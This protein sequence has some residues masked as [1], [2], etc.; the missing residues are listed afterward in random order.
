MPDDRPQLPGST[1]RPLSSARPAG[2]LDPAATAEVTVVLRRRTPLPPA[3][4]LAAP[5]GR[6]EF[7]ATYG[8]DP[9]D[10]AAVRETL[11]AEGL[12]VTG[13]DAASRRVQVRGDVATLRR[14]FAAELEEVESPDPV[15]GRQVTHRQRTGPLAVPTP[16]TEIV[17]AVLGLDDRPQARALFRPA[18][19]VD[20]TF[21]PLE[22]GRVYRFPAGT[23]GSGQT[24]AILEL[25][26]GYTDDD[27]AA[28]WSSVGLADPPRVT[29]VG[30]DGAAN[31]PEGDP[32]GADGEV[33]LD[34]E[35]AG[36][37]APGADLVVYFAPNTDRGF[38]D[39]LTTAVHA[40]PTPT[41]VSISW[42][43]NE[44]EWTAQ[45]RTAMDDAMADAAAL[46]VTVCAAAGDDGSTD[47]A[48]DGQAHVDFPASSPHALACGGTTL[49]AD[50]GTGAVHSET[51][52]FH[53]AGRG[54]TGG[55]VSAV[56]PV[57]AWQAAVGVPGDADTGRPGRGVPDV[58][59]DAD[60]ATGYQVRV[61]GRDT[62]IGG[63][64]AVS[65]LWSAL[66]CRL[67]QALGRRPGLLQPLLYAGVG[68]GAVPA[69]F[70]DVTS[71][72]NG[73]YSA[74][75]GWDPCTG[76]GV[77]DGEALL[78]RLRTAAG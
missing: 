17:T 52:W 70:R 31:A 38:L 64:S 54:G 30:V 23:D 51:V 9:A 55:G 2:A 43:Q 34:I 37:L 5:L 25:G 27:L 66:T 48:T 60:P 76:L 72:G 36:A 73:A 41:A 21:S 77:P 39:A 46:G 7:A 78:A 15:S 6:E 16:L 45:A 57:P 14:V 1:R 44:D 68:A 67:A 32:N 10:L 63:T 53:G 29:A 28:Y 40:D 8:A 22:L 20:T 50:P 11:A 12:E 62:V 61:D 26:G 75:P 24:L 71:G 65:P 18:A 59:A 35:V 47:N 33:L 56:F 4:E 74:G 42:G 19:A 13:E 49:H 3:G 58:A 69:G